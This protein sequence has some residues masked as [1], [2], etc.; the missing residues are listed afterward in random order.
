MK[1]YFPK[2]DKKKSCSKWLPLTGALIAGVAIALVGNHY[3]EWS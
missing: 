2:R 1:S 3:Y